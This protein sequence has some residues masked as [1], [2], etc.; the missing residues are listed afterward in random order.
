MWNFFSGVWGLDHLSS[1]WY[2]SFLMEDHALHD[3]PLIVPSL[4]FILACAGGDLD[5]WCLLLVTSIWEPTYHPSWPW[6]SLEMGPSVANN[7]LS[8]A[9]ACDI[10]YNILYY[11]GWPVR[12]T[13]MVALALGSSLWGRISALT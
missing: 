10:E 11:L 5:A 7:F 8:F 6:P 9:S 2:H 13:T 4:K 12:P 3:F 1:P